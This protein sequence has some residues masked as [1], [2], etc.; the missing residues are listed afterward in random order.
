MTDPIAHLDHI[1][2]VLCHANEGEIDYGVIAADR[3]ETEH[4]NREDHIAITRN[5]QSEIEVAKIIVS[6]IK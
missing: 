5:I 3:S 4:A 2:S 1:T 6:N